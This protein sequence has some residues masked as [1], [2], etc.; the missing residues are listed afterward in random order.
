MRKKFMAVSSS[1]ATTIDMNT[2]NQIVFNTNVVEWKHN[3]NK[4]FS[5]QKTNSQDVLE[6]NQQIILSGFCTKNCVL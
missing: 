1:V 5:M 6:K 2:P 4:Y 3:C